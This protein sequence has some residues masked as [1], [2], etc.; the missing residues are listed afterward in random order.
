M[1][2]FSVLFMLSFQQ[3][4]YTRYIL[5]NA[6]NIKTIAVEIPGTQIVLLETQSWLSIYVITE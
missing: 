3:K 2:P 4:L 5:T 1:A 6:F